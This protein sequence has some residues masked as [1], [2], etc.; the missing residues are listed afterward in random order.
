MLFYY[1]RMSPLNQSVIIMLLY[2]I[3]A[4]GCPQDATASLKDLCTKENSSTI[5]LELAL[6]LFRQ[7]DL[8]DSERG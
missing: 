8:V 2:Y 3:S 6:A 4:L 7:N 5:W 1:Q